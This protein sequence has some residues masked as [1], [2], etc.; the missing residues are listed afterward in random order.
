PPRHPPADDPEPPPRPAAR[1]HGREAASTAGA[2]P[3]LMPVPGAGDPPRPPLS[4]ARGGGAAV[5][6]G[7]TR[8][9]ARGA[10]GRAPRPA[11]GVTPTTVAPASVPSSPGDVPPRDHRPRHPAP[12]VA[13]RR[14]AARADGGTGR[15]G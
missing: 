2:H 13:G 3:R 9:P 12:V 1:R 14:E 10:V 11:S 15:G 4:F 8:T 7:R 6:S 5:G